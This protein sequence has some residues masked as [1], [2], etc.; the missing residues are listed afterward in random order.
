LLL[1]SPDC[2]SNI[3]KHSQKNQE[4]GKIPCILS[5]KTAQ[6]EPEV[7]AD[8]GIPDHRYSGKFIEKFLRTPKCLELLP[9]KFLRKN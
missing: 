7:F 3:R 4:P 6:H 2:G 1:K 8:S 5:G 9:G